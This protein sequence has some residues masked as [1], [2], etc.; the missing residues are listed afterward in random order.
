MR[1][2]GVRGFSLIELMIAVTLSLFLVGVVIAAVVSAGAAA[3]AQQGAS[4][5]QDNARSALR[6]IADDVRRATGSYCLNYTAS[7]GDGIG[8]AAALVDSRRGFEVRFDATSAPYF[9]GPEGAAASSYWLDPSEFVLGSECGIGGSC[10]PLP[11]IF[12]PVRGNALPAVGT[13]AGARARATDVL[14]LRMLTGA[15]TRLDAVAH[16]DAGGDP[17]ELTVASSGI[18]RTGAVLVADCSVQIAMRVNS[19]DAVTLRASGNYADDALPALVPGAARVFD[20]ADLGWAVYF[21][22][23]D[24]DIDR[25]GHR[26]SSLIRRAQGGDELI[27]EGIERFDLLYHVEHADGTTSVLDAAQV[28]SLTDCRRLGSTTAAP[29]AVGCGWRSLKGV[30]VFLL[31]NSGED[32]MPGSSSSSQAGYRYAWLSD[33]DAPNESGIFE[34]VTADTVLP[35]GTQAGRMLRKEYRTYVAIRGLNP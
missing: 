28:Q 18:L 13:G 9:L 16:N 30:E 31:A 12:S 22:R 11:S 24:D 10:N 1:E 3:R 6:R 20:L 7:D 14:G 8:S 26:I 23:L 2:R 33:T 27:A 4:R 15:G 19:T 5:L 17:V 34:A 21:V 29:S 35:N 25:P 32:A